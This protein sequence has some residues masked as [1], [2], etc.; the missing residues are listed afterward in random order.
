MLLASELYFKQVLVAARKSMPRK[1]LQSASYPASV[2][3]T[4]LKTCIKNIHLLRAAN[5]PVVSPE[6]V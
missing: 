2:K 3:H 5:I 1:K 4:E 6:V